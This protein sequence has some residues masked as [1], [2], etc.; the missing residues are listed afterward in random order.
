MTLTNIILLYILLYFSIAVGCWTFHYAKRLFET[1]FIHRFSN[2]T[3]P[4]RNLFKNCA[5]Y[6]IFAGYVAYHVNHPLYTSPALP[7]ALL[8]LGGFVISELGNL[9]IHINLR[10]LRPPGTKVRKIP[11]PDSNPL[12]QLFK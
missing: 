4:L 2:A 5:Y 12:T 1:L 3:M 6:W 11:V 7:Q 9:A 8:A 10:N